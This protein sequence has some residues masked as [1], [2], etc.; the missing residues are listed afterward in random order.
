[1]NIGEPMVLLIKVEDTAEGHKVN[2][3]VSAFYNPMYLIGVSVV[4]VGGVELS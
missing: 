4:E 3:I 1:M 2:T